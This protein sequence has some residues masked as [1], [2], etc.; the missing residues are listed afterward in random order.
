VAELLF[1][2][3]SEELPARFVV[4]ALEELERLFKEQCLA[5]R[6]GH[7]T[8][9]RF[10][11]PRR[12]ALLVDGLIE[13][14]DDVVKE[15][16][17]PSVKAAF[18]A[19]GKPK[20]PAIKFAESVKLPVEK[21]KRVSTAKGEYLAADVEEKGRRTIELLPDVLNACV[22]KLQFPKSMR[23]GDVEQAF[24]RP[25]QW[26]VA[27]FGAEVVPVV[28]ADVKSGR[29]TRGHR[30]LSSGWI[31]LEQPATYEAT[32]EKA[33]VV[34][35]L[36]KRRAMLVERLSAAA[37]KAGGTLISDEA[38]VDQ[39]LNLV[40]LPSPVVGTFEA[41]HLDLPPEVLIQEMKSHQ[42]YFSLTDASGKLLARFIAV[43]NT[44]VKDE[45]LSVKGYERVL[46]AR[47]TDGRFF[48][49]ED[50]K[51]PL[52]DR[53]P[54]LARRNWVQGLGSMAEKSDRMTA[55]ALFLAK[56]TG[57]GDVATIERASFL[58]KCDLETGM[59][60]EFPE[61][62]G[63]M[64]REYARFAKEPEAVGLAV[65]E[66]YLPRGAT[67][68]LPTKDEG[69]LIGLAERIDSLCGLF[70]IGKKPTGAKDEFALRRAAIA[71][72]NLVIGRGYRFSLAAALD[73][74]LTL[75][76]P[77]LANAKKRTPNAQVKAEVLEFLRDRLRPLWGEQFRADIIDAVVAAGSDDL[78]SVRQRLEAISVYVARP[79]FASLA[80]TFKRVSNIVEKQAKDI[81]RG[82]I[83]DGK[84][85]DAAEKTLAAEVAK[86]RGAVHTS[87]TSDDYAGAL[88]K[89]V[90]LRPLVDAFFDQVMVMAEDPALRTN[91]VRLLME[92]GGL[93]GTVADFSKIQSEG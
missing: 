64:G 43:S 50:R 74:S 44:P 67:D 76:E 8:I 37:Q 72:I 42:R 6:V 85:T 12:L 10:G 80:A 69:A 23:W 88:A 48:F 89:V 60:G 47:L 40:E 35:S 20:V 63:V 66:H 38:L 53:R 73:E 56:A 46:R 21:L 58:A 34:A 52:Q 54:K 14:T 92:I 18:E 71:V 27:L 29:Q 81:T 79:E 90:P 75:L 16:Q 41:R 7:G 11:S 15:V 17:G 68:G 86:V 84:L 36:D 32:L 5:A 49:D 65:F 9:R 55:L 22:K 28:F 83:D 2:L 91:R 62:Q 30:F 87:I 31:T 70:A 39:V 19:D 59:V 4:P 82:A 3:G 45:A 78:V 61:L 93:F 13:K 25:L 57:K 51:A 24:G 1:E 33:H 77:V 26:I